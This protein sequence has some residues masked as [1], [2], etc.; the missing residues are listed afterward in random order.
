[1]GKLKSI[2]DDL[3][4]EYDADTSP[5]DLLGRILARRRR[6]RGYGHQENGASGIGSFC[7]KKILFAARNN[8]FPGYGFSEAWFVHPFSRQGRI[9][10]M[11]NKSMAIKIYCF[12]LWRWACLGYWGF[13]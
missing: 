2:A 5:E 8:G 6:E 13:R 3:N 10:C 4:V 1:M 12:C 11:N 7:G 9:I